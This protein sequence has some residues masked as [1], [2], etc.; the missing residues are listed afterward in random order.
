[1]DLG[2]LIRKA[3]QQ[4]LRDGPT[5]VAGAANVGGRGHTSAVYSD[6]D[7]TIVHR[8][9]V[10]HVIRHGETEPDAPPPSP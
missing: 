2:R 6:D 1:M 3:V 10:T 5:N 4:A 9:G 7:V 8:D